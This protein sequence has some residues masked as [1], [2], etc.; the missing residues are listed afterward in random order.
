MKKIIFLI[1]VVGLLVSCSGGVQQ[2]E[3]PDAL[4]QQTESIEA[5]TQSLDSTMQD[6]EKEMEKTQS[7]IDSLLN[8]I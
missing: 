3:S 1:P 7:E 2:K 8:G 6:S 5:S 4:Q